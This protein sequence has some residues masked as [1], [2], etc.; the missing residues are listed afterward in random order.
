LRIVIE[1]EDE[2]YAKVAWNEIVL[3]NNFNGEIIWDGKF[4]DGTIAPAGEYLV[5]IKATDKA[6]NERFG[7]GRVIVPEPNAIFSLFQSTTTNN[8]EALLPP[9]ELFDEEDSFTANSSVT[10]AS[11]SSSF[12][13]STT[14]TQEITQNS[15]ALATG[16]TSS[17]TTTN[18]NVLWGATAATM[19]GATMAYAL[20]EKRKR[21]EEEAREL[22]E[23]YAKAA[24]LNAAEEQRK[25]NGWL[26]GQ[27]ML[28]AYIEAAEG[29]GATDA[30]IAELRAQGATQGFS[31]AIAEAEVAVQTLFAQNV[32]RQQ[33]LDAFR[34][35]ERND[36]AAAAWQAEQRRI[37]EQRKA[38]ELQAGLLAYYN[39]MRQ[40]EQA[41]QTTWLEKAVD[42]V[43]ESIVQPVQEAVTAIITPALSVYTP[44]TPHLALITPAPIRDDLPNWLDALKEKWKD[45]KTAIETAVHNTKNSIRIA[46]DATKKQWEKFEKVFHNAY[47][48]DL[49]EPAKEDEIMAFPD[50]AA[51]FTYIAAAINVQRDGVNYEEDNNSH[52]GPAQLSRNELD[53][54]YGE[55]FECKQK[56]KNGNLTQDCRGYGVGLRGTDP[57][58]DKT[59]VNGMQN[60]IQQVIEEAENKAKKNGV[61]LDETDIFIIAALSQNSGSFDLNDIQEVMDNPKYTENGII[62]WQKYFNFKYEKWL[63]EKK[64]DEPFWQVVWKKLKTGSSDKDWGTEFML[65]LFYQQA[66]TLEGDG[67][68]LPENLDTEQIEALMNTSDT[69]QS[70]EK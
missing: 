13:G 47:G 11:Q 29:Q 66:K 67:Y 19:I 38:E 35:A 21:K 49:I 14:Q 57:Y 43:Q 26:Q 65:E 3:G 5:W 54:D 58:D 12:G 42:F 27:A 68:Y 55:G 56:D 28:E 50:M 39:G 16:A 36:A 31:V 30:Q 32:A 22:E 24:K 33:A 61:T 64:D 34:A 52:L 46:W 59:A 9:Q 6:G 40:G 25:I 53:T 23:A 69:I 63:E 45:T 10:T 41:A 44:H 51:M 70:E 7:L 17:S 18:S 1:H 4:A 20:D 37:E 2:K 62:D 15:L 8:Q 60:R 48:Q